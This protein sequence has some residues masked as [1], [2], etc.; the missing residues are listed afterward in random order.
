MNKNLNKYNKDAYDKYK[1]PN[2]N[3]SYDYGNKGMNL[4]YK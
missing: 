4:Y 3:Q 1:L 2:V